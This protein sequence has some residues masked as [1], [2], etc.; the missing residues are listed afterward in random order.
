MSEM[1]K[2][3]P[4]LLTGSHRSG[5]TWIGKMIA[6]SSSIVYIREPF[7]VS[8]PPG[9][10]INS[11]EFSYWYTY[12]YQGNEDCFYSPIKETLN[13]SYGLTKE[14]K[15]KEAKKALSK[16]LKE[17]LAFRK[18]K[19]LGKRP[20]LK[21]PIALF[22]AEWLASKFDMNVVVLIRHPAAFA[23]SL[24]QKNWSFPFSD[25]LKQTQLIKDHLY[26]FEA[27]LKSY[28]D[29]KYD[30][31][32]QASLLWK[33]LHYMILKYQANH[34]EWLFV[35]HEDIS[36]KPL[37]V[38]QDIF[39]YLD[40]EF[41]EK[42]SQVIREHSSASN[43]VE[44][45]S[46]AT[47]TLKRNSKDNIKSWKHRLTDTEIERIRTQVEEIACHFYSEEDWL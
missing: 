9:V 29:G 47:H 18:N 10:G 19:L 24:K 41:T 30:I 21:D 44:G 35:R 17:F 34:S 22:S 23:S 27:D 42:I 12:I 25:F 45:S 11:A 2:K 13:F 15:A 36:E 40:L 43:P 46:D 16:I 28:V 5:S 39:S 4:I 6:E 7:N 3:K 37:P 31:I 14:L 1:S 20:L 33:I 32:D 8:H 26:P 38:F